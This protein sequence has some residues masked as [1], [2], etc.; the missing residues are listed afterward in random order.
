[1]VAPRRRRRAVEAGTTRRRRTGADNVLSRRTG[2]E[3]ASG[4]VIEGSG[5]EILIPMLPNRP[6]YRKLR[7]KSGETF[8][9]VSD[10]IYKCPRKLILAHAHKIAMVE[11]PLFASQSLTFRMG[12]AI[13]DHVRDM[14]AKHNPDEIFARWKCTCGAKKHIGTLTKALK[15]GACDKCGTQLTNHNELEVYNSTLNVVG[16]P[17]LLIYRSRAF[18]INEVKSMAARYWDELERPQPD[19]IIQVLLYWYLMREAGKALHD[20]VS[21]LYVCKDF[22]PRTPYKE[23]T[24]HA[25]SLMDRLE[26]Y[27]AEAQRIKAGI[28]GEGY[29]LPARTVCAN[30]S[31]GE[32]K[33]CEVCTMCFSME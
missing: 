10:L 8:I 33:K 26:P 20:H 2:G 5:S 21:I 22:R 31:S 29:P 23:Y 16:S 24:L 28:E 27:L 17:D 1:M 12:E 14:I 15:Q 18:Y 30:E 3:G 7:R 6:E 25:A 32:A 9:H 19:H 4:G 13:H 11:D